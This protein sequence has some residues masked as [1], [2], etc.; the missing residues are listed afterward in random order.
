MKRFEVILTEDKSV[1]IDADKFE[2]YEPNEI[3]FIQ[4]RPTEVKAVFNL[5]N[6]MGFKEKV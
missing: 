3:L 6:I 5:G 1:Y 2:R 4:E